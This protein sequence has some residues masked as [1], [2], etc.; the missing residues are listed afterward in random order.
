MV[1]EFPKWLVAVCFAAFLLL[2][3]LT[4]G[5][6]GAAWDERDEMDILL[7][8]LLEYVRA[9]DGNESAFEKREVGADGQVTIKTLYI[10]ISKSVEQDHGICTFYPMAGIVMGE[11]ITEEQRSL[12]WHMWCWVIFTLG[13]YA[14][15]AVC[16]QLGLSRGFAML[17]P[18]FLLLTPQFFA[19]GHFNNKDIAIMSLALCVL[20]QGIRLMKKPT[21]STGLLFA[22]AG[23]MA[24]NTKVAGLALWG[25][26]ALFVL[27]Y[28]LVMRRMTGCVWAVAGVTLLAFLGI[29]ALLTPAMWRDPMAFFN[30]C[31]LNAFSFQRWKNIL[32]FRGTVF[33]LTGQPLPWYYLPYM[34]VVTTPAW[35][36]LLLFAG[37]VWGVVRAAR[38]RKWEQ[39]LPI[40]LT[41]LLWALPLG[42]AVITRTNVYNGW[43]HFYFVYGPMLVLAVLGVEAAFRRLR[44]KALRRAFACA[45]ALCMVL[46]G[47]GMVCEH[48]YQYAYYQ[49][50]V[51]LRGDGFLERDYWN[52]SV[53]DALLKLA[54]T[55]E[56]ELTITEGDRCSGYGLDKALLV[57]PQDV[58]Q[59]F[60]RVTDGEDAQ[61]VLSNPLY[62]LFA[63]FAPTGLQEVLHLSAYGETL[64]T[65]YEREGTM[66]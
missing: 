4:A 5:D 13:A 25:L 37:N 56:G 24:A 65:V 57:L 47:A 32:L 59:R 11:H 12:H 39:A 3:L 22:L 18:L 61:Y 42:V 40:M 51:R 63:G 35:I 43:R 2:G 15:Y 55:R 38:C 26:A 64:C 41:L 28:Q 36:L 23:A 31:V 49:P 44:R 45:L 66:Q 54:E 60:R 1:K 53:R 29:Y 19:H 46:T 58:A 16:R 33:N 52:I 62:G 21:F 48:P 17:G 7:M 34:V 14:L 10:P 6:Y 50:I 30:H 9:F 20:W 27:V 8:N